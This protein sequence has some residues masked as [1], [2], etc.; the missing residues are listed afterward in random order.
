MKKREGLFVEGNRMS[1]LRLSMVVLLLLA[2]AARAQQADAPQ[3]DPSPPPLVPAE[4]E[5]ELPAPP[6][7]PQP[8]PQLQ[9][10]TIANPVMDPADL[11]PQP[12]P[13]QPPQAQ[14]PRYAQPQQ[15]SVSQQAAPGRPLRI[16]MGLLFGLGAGAV[17]GLAGLGVGAMALPR[18]FLSPIGG[19]AA[20]AVLGFAV[21]APIGVL[22]SGLI[23]DGDGSIWATLLGDVLGLAVG[24]TATLIG[25]LEG[26]PLCFALP[27]AG[28][29]LGYEGTSHDSRAAVVPTVSFAPGR[30][31][32][33]GLA[34]S[35]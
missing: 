33:L 19:P 9:P 22:V 28:S 14:P 17:T 6:P 3:A 13:L 24:A 11:G 7:T 29:V 31:G 16:G 23:F 26:I 32:S 21:G 5:P 18:D 1:P 15:P 2:S 27:L 8:E 10:P 35:F 30:G 12:Q 25:G 34:G 20:G 4:P